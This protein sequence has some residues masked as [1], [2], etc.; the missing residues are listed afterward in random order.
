MLLD[1]V[2]CVLGIWLLLFG[3]FLCLQT[4]LPLFLGEFDSIPLLVR[5]MRND[6]GMP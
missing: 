4:L 3:F 1:F 6:K 5:R 2:F